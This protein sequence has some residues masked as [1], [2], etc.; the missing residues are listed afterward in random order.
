VSLVD[1]W[2]GSLIQK[3]DALGLADR[4]MVILL[5]DHGEPL[6]EHGIIKKVRPW[7][8]EEL[9]HFPLILRPPDGVDVAP[10]RLDQFVSMPDVMPTVLDL[11]GVEIPGTVQGRS[12]LK[13]ISGEAKPPEFGV[14]G[15]YGRSWSVRDREWSFYLWPGGKAPYTWGIGYP[16]PSEGERSPELYKLDSSYVPPEPARWDPENDVA[17]KDNVIGD[18]TERARSMELNLRRFIHSLSPSPGDMMAQESM[19]TEFRQPWLYGIIQ[20]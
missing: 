17:E 1:R 7:P 2:F 6:G 15:H 13:V 16:K 8:Y 11:L 9:S 10:Q 14:S 12:L 5:S 20:R 18:H 4:T 3:V 19:K